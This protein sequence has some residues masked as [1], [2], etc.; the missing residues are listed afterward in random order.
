MNITILERNNIPKTVLFAKVLKKNTLNTNW[1]RDVMVLIHGGPGGNHTLYSDIEDSLLEFADL[2]IIDLRGC[3]LSEKSDV[4]YCTLENHIDDLEPFFKN[5]NIIK[6]IIHGCSYGA[7][8][9]LGYAIKYPDNLSALILSSG[10]ASG[11]F[12]QSAKTNLNRLGT[13]EQ[14]EVAKQLWNGTFENIEQFTN[15]YQTMAMLYIYKKNVQVPTQS[16][17]NIPYNI[18]L[19][20]LAFRTFLRTFD[21][22]DQLKLVVTNTLIFSGKN[23]WIMDTTQAE[24]LNCGIDNSVLVT[25]EECGHFPW[26]DKRHEFLT[27]IQQFLENNCNANFTYRQS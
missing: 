2:V 25:L 13:P 11:N 20:N 6:P 9:A 4:Q 27:H 17:I 15:Y 18:D 22:R 23:D 24:I 5:L 10:A 19:V 3:G 12:I 26:K 21:F 1:D 16:T 8:V 14:I 7:L